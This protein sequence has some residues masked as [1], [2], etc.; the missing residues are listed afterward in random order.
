MKNFFAKFILSVLPIAVV[1]SLFFIFFGTENSLTRWISFGFCNLAY[2]C[3][4]M[5]PLFAN[6]GKFMSNRASLWYISGWYL[7][8][9]L[10]PGVICIWVNPVD[11]RW[12][13]IVQALLCIIFVFWFLLTYITNNNINQSIEEQKAY[14]T[15]IKMLT[16]QLKNIQKEFTD[17]PEL[18]AK[19][20]KSC[21]KLQASP[22]RSCE[23]IKDIE[24]EIAIYIAEING[25]AV[26]GDDE[27]IS[28][29][30]TKLNKKI[31][32]RNTT[33]KFNH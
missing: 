3:L 28:N 6:S 33:L 32:E 14:S 13:L 29:L 10:I 18:Y 30:T 12:P 5:T 20:D 8:L 31:D 15:R 24:E 4:I 26:S 16:L 27:T 1:D 25:A 17:K 21:L 22:I 19:I 9:E 23:E 2:L 11:Y 7:F